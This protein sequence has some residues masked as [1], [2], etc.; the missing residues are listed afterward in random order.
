[1]LDAIGGGTLDDMFGGAGDEGTGYHGHVIWPDE[2]PQQGRPRT[3][4]PILG[5]NPIKEDI[6]RQELAGNNTEN[7][8]PT[9]N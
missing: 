8:P 9:E 4:N 5:N 1:M 2:E 3:N 6:F 7:T